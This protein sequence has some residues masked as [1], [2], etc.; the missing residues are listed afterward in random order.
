MKIK[1]LN[2][3]NLI[4]DL[5]RPMLIAGPCS[6][7]SEEQVLQTARALA[8][9]SK[10]DIYRAGIW[11]PRTRPNAF[12]GVGSRGLAWLKRAK[13]E[14]G[15]PV[16]TEVANTTHVYEALK[17]GIDVLWIGART[18]ANPFAMQEIADALKGIDIPV[19]VKNPITPDLDLWIGA[20][21][22]IYNAGI[23]RVGA[24][25]RG[26]SN[27]EKTMYRNLPQW[28]IPIEL[29]SRIPEIPLLN[30]PSHIGGK[31][32][33][34]Y[35]LSQQAMDLNFDGLMIETHL[36]PDTALSD[37]KQQ[38]TPGKLK[39]IINK[40][41]V[42]K[43]MTDDQKVL[44][45]LEELRSKINILDEQLLVTLEQRMKI[46]EKIGIYKKKNNLTILQNKRWEEIIYS[47]IK[48]GNEK[49]ISRLAIN[50]I[51][52]AIHQESI[53]HQTEIMKREKK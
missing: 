39:E 1:S 52:K 49:G 40:L 15:L 18:S 31:R 30:D 11:K 45:E 25:H 42:R 4:K 50:R 53:N 17:F 23:T 47:M 38:I 24:I 19:F 27:Y 33:L 29:K 32:K 48:K 28:Q 26:F 2:N 46:A 10:V 20:I 21:E 6:A 8:E 22:R 43:P 12:E 35:N 36:N 3:W 14:T 5:R 16:C 44:N 7:E 9:N 13:K 37:A 34:I 51:F 41:V